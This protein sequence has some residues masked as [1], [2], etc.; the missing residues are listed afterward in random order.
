M[1][2]VLRLQ[3]TALT[4]FRPPSGVKEAEMQHSQSLL[5]HHRLKAYAA[6]CALLEAVRSA[7]I[8]DARFR[9]QALRA[10]ASVCLNSAEAAGRS[11]AADRK[12][13][14]GIARGEV[15]EAVAAVEVAVRGGSARASALPAVLEAGNQAY[16]LLTGLLR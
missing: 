14:F 10:A 3:V 13:V 12:R 16:A 9:D 5:P 7:Q 15:V 1:Q 4:D 8:R 2:N 11:G 6:A